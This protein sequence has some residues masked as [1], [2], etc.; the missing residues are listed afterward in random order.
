MNSSIKAEANPAKGPDDRAAS[1]AGKEDHH[2]FRRDSEA[3]VSANNQ[4]SAN[5]SVLRD[6]ADPEPIVHLQP[7]I[8]ASEVA[9]ELA[10]AKINERGEVE[11]TNHSRMAINFDGDAAEALSFSH[12]NTNEVDEVNQ[13][14]AIR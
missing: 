13:E 14:S 12:M 10:E 2:S 6:D 7:T 1:N 5:C 11:V 4:A 8:G 3:T 9:D